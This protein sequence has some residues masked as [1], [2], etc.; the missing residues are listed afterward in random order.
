MSAVTLS[1]LATAPVGNTTKIG[2]R[3][4]RRFRR[5]PEIPA[6]PH[7]R[8]PRN[9]PENKMTKAV[10]ND[11]EAPRDGTAADPQALLLAQAGMLVGA[12]QML[13]AAPAARSTS[14][15]SADGGSHN[16]G[17]P[18]RG[19]RPDSTPSQA[20]PLPG[21]CQQWLPQRR[22]LRRRRPP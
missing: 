17:G 18:C 10:A 12:A 8:R 4:R 16:T 19:R 20:T 6:S 2:Q 3:R 11:G 15:C 13:A 1:L 7:R 22:T 5:F 21:P 9:S 14:G